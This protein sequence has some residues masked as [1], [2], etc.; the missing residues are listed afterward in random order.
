MNILFQSRFDRIR[1][2]DERLERELHSVE[3]DVSAI[4]ENNTIEQKPR[5]RIASK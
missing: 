5:R 2:A 1:I 3:A 4:I